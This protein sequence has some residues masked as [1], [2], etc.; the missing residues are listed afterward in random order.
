LRLFVTHWRWL[1]WRGKQGLM[2][3]ESDASGPEYGSRNYRY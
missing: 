3:D 1:L 2:K